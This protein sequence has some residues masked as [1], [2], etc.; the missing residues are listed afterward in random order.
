M[1]TARKTYADPDTRNQ[2]GRTSSN[3]ENAVKVV[4]CHTGEG[5]PRKEKKRE[6]RKK[7]KARKE[8]K[9]AGEPRASD[10]ELE[11]LPDAMFTSRTV[12]SKPAELAARASR[13]PPT[14]ILPSATVSRGRSTQRQ[15][16]PSHF[17]SPSH[18]R[19]PSC[20]Q[21]RSH[22]GAP[23]ALRLGSYSR[24]C[25]CSH[26]PSHSHSHSFSRTT[27][28]AVGLR[29]GSPQSGEK[30]ARPL[31]DDGEEEEE[32]EHDCHPPPPVVHAQKLNNDNSRPKAAD[33]DSISQDTI[34]AAASYYRVLLFTENT[35]PDSATKV[36][37]LRRAWKHANDDSG[38]EHLLLDAD[39]AKIVKACGSQARGKAKSKTQALF[40]VLYRFDSGCGKSAIKK[41]RDKA[42]RL[43][44]EKG[45]VYKEL[46]DLNDPES[47]RKGMYQHPIIQKAVNC[48]WFKN[49]RDEGILFETL[50][51][52]MPLPAIALLLTAIEAN[53]DEWLTRIRVAASFFADEYRKV[54][55]SHLNSLMSFADYSCDQGI[56]KRL[57]WRWYNYG[58]QHAGAPSTSLKDIP[59]IPVSVFA[60]AVLEYEES[61]ETDDDGDMLID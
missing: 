57:R 41:N 20:S 35:F 33:Y 50:F 24:S 6:E 56:V 48:M 38:M 5:S 40:E 51:E 7:K 39:V 11:E 55:A 53:I 23:S 61:S 4:G 42:E 17:Q 2:A 28:S 14:P 29:S 46:E 36:Q 26:P 60:A 45:F 9:E 10:D 19:T 59:A 58:H 13:I 21:S 47:H 32:E 31:E 16:P 8:A 15:V 34:L 27:T 12:V 30:H 37:F 25:S 52:G 3:K 54:Y 44:H 43:K 49:R 18:S 1:P 22:L